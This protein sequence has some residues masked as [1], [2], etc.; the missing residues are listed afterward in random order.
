M[1]VHAFNPK[2]YPVYQSTQQVPGHIERP[3]LKNK[4]VNN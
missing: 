2:A 3:Y 1:E 4:K